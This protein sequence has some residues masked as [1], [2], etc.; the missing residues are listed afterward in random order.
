M[1]RFLPLVGAILCV[2]FAPAQADVIVGRSSDPTFLV[3]AT[4]NTYPFADDLIVDFSGAVTIQS[5]CGSPGNG[6][7]TGMISP[8]NNA[9]AIFNWMPLP[10]P[11]PFQSGLKMGD[12]VKFTITAAAGT[13]IKDVTWSSGAASAIQ[14]GGS[15]ITEVPE[16]SE[17]VPLLLGVLVM[18]GSTGYRRGH[19]P[20]PP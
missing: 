20:I 14:N 19:T 5:C 7:F 6:G 11:L 17:F 8:T 9:R 15:S 12:T 10:P 4:N 18:V 13:M 16:P 1:K 2:G 3:M